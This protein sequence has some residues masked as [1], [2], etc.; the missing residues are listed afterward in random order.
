MFS[1]HLKLRNLELET[2]PGL[3]RM[4][5]VLLSLTVLA[6]SL[7]LGCGPGRHLSIAGY[8]TEPPFDPNI[9]SVYIPTFKLNCFVTDPYKKLDVDI[10]EAVVREITS[11]RSP[12]RIVSDPALAD[13]E[14]IGTIT[15]VTKANYVYNVQALPRDSEVLIAVAVVW[16]DLRSGEVLTNPK[17]GKLLPNP[18]PNTF[19]PSVEPPPPRVAPGVRNPVTITGKGRL[20]PELGESNLTAAN[21]ASASIARQIVNL[22]ERPW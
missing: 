11:R 3:I 2:F 10:T 17:S 5:R 6:S 9:R 19:D 18:N 12:I 14:L 22:M 8:T 7:L 21:T 1:F 20:L 16:R 13:T 15:S 4:K